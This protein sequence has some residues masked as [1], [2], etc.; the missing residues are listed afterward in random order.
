MTRAQ[1]QSDVQVADML[2]Q[3]HRRHHQLQED[4]TVGSTVHG[5]NKQYSMRSYTTK[6]NE[7]YLSRYGSKPCPRTVSKKDGTSLEIF[8][9]SGSGLSTIKEAT[10]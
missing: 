10:S 6:Y 7:H 8:L 1:A 5:S 9:S 2:L 3:L 4:R